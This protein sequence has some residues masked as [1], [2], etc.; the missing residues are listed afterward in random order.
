MATSESTSNDLN[1]ESG[2]HLDIL[3]HPFIECLVAVEHS[4]EPTD[5]IQIRGE[6][7]RSR[8]DQVQSKQRT[9]IRRPQTMNG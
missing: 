8:A 9:W 3:F 4:V 6:P 1:I 5:T 7:L 2:A